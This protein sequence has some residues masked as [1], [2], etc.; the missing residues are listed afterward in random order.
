LNINVENYV[1]S[2]ESDVKKSRYYTKFTKL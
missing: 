2:V 1:E